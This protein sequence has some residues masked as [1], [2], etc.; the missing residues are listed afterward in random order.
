MVTNPDVPEPEEVVVPNQIPTIIAELSGNHNGSLERA[1]DLV[2]AVATTGASH[3]KIQTYTAETIT[4][5]VDQ[6][7]FRIPDDHPLW[8]GRTLFDLYEEAHTPWPWHEPIFELAR[9]L[10]LTPFSTPF[11]PSAVE[12]L[13]TLGTPLY[14][15]A[16]LEIGDLP[17]IR[18]IGRTGK[19]MIISTGASN[20]GE[21]DR[22]VTAATTSGCG[23]LTLLVCTSAYPAPPEEAN[24]RRIITLREAFGLPVG[25]SD[26]TIGI[27]V[28]VAAAA[29][30]ASV[31]EKHVTLARGDRGVD[32]E[33]SAEPGELKQL[34]EECHRAVVALGSPVVAATDSES[35]SRA[36]RRSLYVAENVMEGDVVSHSNVRS[37]RPAGGLPP[38]L[39]D[40]V[41]GTKFSTNASLGTPLSWDLLTRRDS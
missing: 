26:H 13:E 8:G 32:A 18:E 34:V 11:D 20:L 27:G 25:L 2:R 7:P 36:L 24:L 41:I 19:P 1:L 17:L 33:F 16:S 39:L 21:I 22:A 6:A 23:S 9:S 3:V 10:R 31:I 15:V 37:V 4:L 28:S 40:S 5:N 29:L 12:F 30:G 35:T 14:K 38:E